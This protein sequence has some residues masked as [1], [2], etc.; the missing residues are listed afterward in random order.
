LSRGVLGVI[1]C[2]NAIW[3]DTQA[4]CKFHGSLV[5]EN[6]VAFGLVHLY[7]DFTPRAARVDGHADT[8]QTMDGMADNKVIHL[9]K[10]LDLSKNSPFF[11]WYM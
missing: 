3:R 11:Q 7:R 9:V 8:I 10:K 6:N 5:A 4:S 1:E 2:E